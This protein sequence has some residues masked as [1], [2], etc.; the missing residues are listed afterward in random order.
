[1]LRNQDMIQNE[2][3]QSGDSS[4]WWPFFFSSVSYLHSNRAWDGASQYLQSGAQQFNPGV[5]EQTFREC[6]Q[7]YSDSKRRIIRGG[8]ENYHHG[9]QRDIWWV[10]SW[11][12][13]LSCGGQP[14][15]AQELIIQPRL[16]RHLWVSSIENY[17]CC[18]FSSKFCVYH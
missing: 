17:K 16:H 5:M 14:Q 4:K 1:M 18:I 13:L 3:R 7:L 11:E 2:L 6:G 15:W 10:V 8:E 12:E 9:H